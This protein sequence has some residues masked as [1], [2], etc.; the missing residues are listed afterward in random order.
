MTADDPGSALAAGA[1]RLCLA[2]GFCCNGTLHTNTV[3]QIDE[4]DRAREVGLT[5]EI[6][7]AKL[8]FKQP[9]PMFQEDHC[10]I[11]AQRP[12]VCRRYECA[13][14]KRYLAGE[15]TLERALKVVGI[16][17][18]Q[19]AVFRGKVPS[20]PSFMHWLRAIEAIADSPEADAQA[21][22]LLVDA[23]VSDHAAALIVY[24]TRYF[25]E[26]PDGG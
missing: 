2:C 13:L 22:A 20:A 23:E 5:V 17:R 16:A 24:L 8:A 14:L 1:E 7:G 19:L 3:L 10:V 4:V 26:T 12:H 18:Q 6:V 21:Q 15:I 25:G 11:Y 9:C